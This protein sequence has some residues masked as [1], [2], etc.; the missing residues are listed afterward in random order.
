MINIPPMDVLMLIELK[1]W[2]LYHEELS[3]IALILTI[4]F[5]AFVCIDMRMNINVW[6]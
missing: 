5:Y 6:D 1:I 4:P 3:A 2:N